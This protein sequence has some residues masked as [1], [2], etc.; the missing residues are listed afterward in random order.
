MKSGLS[1]ARIGDPELDQRKCSAFGFF[2][3]EDEAVLKGFDIQVVFNE[4][5]V[6]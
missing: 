1:K 3:G 4:E 6:Q 2:Y 5:A